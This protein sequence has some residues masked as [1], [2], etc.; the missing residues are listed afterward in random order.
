MVYRHFRLIATLR[1]IF[2]GITSFL[3][4]YL[5]LRTSL[6]AVTLITGLVVLYQMI[7]L[8]RYVEKTNKD[9][10]RFL[11]AIRY[12]DFSQ[13]F[14]GPSLGAS[15]DEVK[16][17]FNEV[18][19][20]FKQ[21]RSEKE[22]HF[23]YL[24]TVVQHVGIGLL[25]FQ[26]N[27]DIELINTAAKRLLKVIRLKNIDQFA[28]LNPE[29]VNRLK[30]MKA[31]EKA[32]IKVQDNSDLLQLAIY[33]TE[34]R[35]RGQKFTL[36]SIQ[37]IQSEL[38]EK[39]ME[40]WQNLIRVLTHEIMNSVTPISSLAST[41]HSLLELE[42]DAEKKISDE[43]IKDVRDAVQ[44]IEKRSKGL[45]HFVESYRKLTRIP[46]PNFQ[47]FEVAALFDRVTQLM[48]MHIADAKITFK[49]GIEPENLELTA[50]AE[51][52]EQ[53][54]INVLL[55]AID[56]VR[57]LNHPEIE[58]VSRIDERGRAIIQVIDNGPGIPKEVQEK[59]FIPFF[60]TKKNGSG[61]G[62]SL[63]RQILRLHRGTISV[64]SSSGSRT[65][66]TLRF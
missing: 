20:K 60:T 28:A 3:F 21:T 29:L 31:G 41:A 6:Y 18:L 49:S 30:N 19:E 5:I 32:L 50:D 46:R 66:V 8:I 37:N 11:D 42:F 10:S 56:A 64:Q 58:L 1:I 44:T 23:R 12:E 22:E 25:T 38:E 52:I 26:A 40:A 57:N 48:N 47:I 2:I 16:K 43:T 13:S 17:A 9:L 27:G 54:L 15:F 34:F 36:V 61:I 62:L 55:N 59:I 33:A 63:S 65:A 35:M 51:L 45:L 14:S 7:S 4:V 39:E 53:V 24:Q